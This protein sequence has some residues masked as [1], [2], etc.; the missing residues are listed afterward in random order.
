C[1]RST[2]EVV[3]QSFDS[4]IF[5]YLSAVSFLQA[6]QPDSWKPGERNEFRQ[7]DRSSL[8]NLALWAA[9]PGNPDLES[10]LA[11]PLAPATNEIIVGS[12]IWHQI[13]YGGYI[14][15]ETMRQTH[16]CA[17]EIEVLFAA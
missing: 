15:A 17:L 4:D 9:L 12:E 2:I 14:G 6:D 5:R 10:M 3:T 8:V 13:R 7:W 16:Q 1:I 11:D